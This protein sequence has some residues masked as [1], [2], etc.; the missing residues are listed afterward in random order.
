MVTT[1][2]SLAEVVESGVIRSSGTITDMDAVGSQTRTRDGGSRYVDPD[3]YFTLNALPGEGAVRADPGDIQGADTNG[4]VE[5]TAEVDLEYDIGFEPSLD[6]EARFDFLAL[7]YCK[8]VATGEFTLDALAQFEL[9]AQAERQSDPVKLFGLSHELVYSIGPV[10]VWQTLGIDF[11]ADLIFT[12]AAALNIEAVYEAV[13]TIQI[14]LEWDNATGWSFIHSD[15]FEQEITFDIHAEGTLAATLRVYPKIYTKF[16]SAVSGDLYVRPTLTLDAAARFIPTPVELTQFDVDFLVD[17]YV[18]AALTIFDGLVPPWTSDTWTML[19][20]PIYSLPT[21]E[22]SSASS[23]IS[24]G[25]ASTFGI[26]V[27]DGVNNAVP[28][29]NISWWIERTGWVLP[30]VTPSADRL[31]AD[32]I[33]SRLANHTLWV[34]V[35]GDGFLGTLGRRYAST[36]FTV[37]E[38]PVVGEDMVR[39]AGGTFQMGDSFNEG[40]SSERPVHT[41]SVSSFY[42]G[43][44]EVTK[45]LWDE[46]YAWAVGNAYSFGNAGSGKGTQH[47]VHTVNWWDMVKWCNARSEKEGL[48][49]CYYTSSGKTAVYRTGQMDLRNDWVRWDAEGYR[50]PTEAEWEYAARGGLAGK[51]FPWGDTIT[52][53]LAN[54]YS[55]SSY[56]YDVSSTRGYHPDYDDGGTPYTSPVGSFPDNDYGLYDMAGNVWEW[57]WDWYG[58]YTSA[59]QTDP[60]GPVS[61][62]Y[63]VFRGGSWLHY[64]DYCRCAGRSVSYPATSIFYVGFR[65]VRA[66]L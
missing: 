26:D 28:A 31:S 34:S 53:E 10:P 20:I 45:A 55:S 18:T 4:T 8:V 25:T 58:S 64:A 43:R 30:S 66:A 2:A 57:C 65:L 54:Y 12:A 62:S 13:K 15:G 33:P 35:Y 37:T 22:F 56:S 9:T 42:I 5:L 40:W 7:K 47:P 21:V 38:A 19:D 6:V 39:I 49:P 17:S 41:V 63:R 60:S 48:T 3:G 23:S 36:D 1:D 16:Y 29:E 61:G 44:H 27:T 32:V 14:G 50:L 52:H 59:S 11:Y 24:S 51:R 46:V